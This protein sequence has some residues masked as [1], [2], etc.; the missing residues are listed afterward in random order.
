MFTP[1]RLLIA[2]LVVFLIG[3]ALG[4]FNVDPASAWI[5]TAGMALFAAGLVWLA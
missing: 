4:S 1:V 5:G 2:G 3:F